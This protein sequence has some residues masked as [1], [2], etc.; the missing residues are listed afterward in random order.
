MAFDDFRSLIYE[1]SSFTLE[2]S[3]PLDDYGETNPYRIAFLALQGWRLVMT[4]TFKPLFHQHRNQATSQ[5]TA[6]RLNATLIHL[7]PTAW[8]MASKRSFGLVCSMLTLM[9]SLPLQ[10]VGPSVSCN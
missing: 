5:R 4:A 3:R 9:V 7:L 6:Q 2:S 8:D 1:L 10:Y